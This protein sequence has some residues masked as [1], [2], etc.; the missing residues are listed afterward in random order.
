MK[1]I[2]SY[3][4]STLQLPL[5]IVPATWTTCCITEGGRRSKG[6]KSF[7]TELQ[8]IFGRHLPFKEYI[9]AASLQFKSSF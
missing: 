8:E 6:H 2:L 5:Q 9:T 3:G 1:S 4:V 7:L